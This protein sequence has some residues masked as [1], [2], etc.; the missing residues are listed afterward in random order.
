MIFYTGGRRAEYIIKQY[1][2]PAQKEVG[3]KADDF[4]YA[5]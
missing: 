5:G 3:L 2:P 4:L 1:I